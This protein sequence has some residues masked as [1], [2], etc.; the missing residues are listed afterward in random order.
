MPDK[1]SDN[2]LLVSLLTSQFGARGRY[3]RVQ[4][5]RFPDEP[6]RWREEWESG[7]IPA[8]RERGPLVAWLISALFLGA[9]AVVAILAWDELT[10]GRE[11]LLWL[12]LIFPLVGVLMLV[13]ALIATARALRYGR[14]VLRL[15]ATPCRLG[16]HVQGT[17]D[18]QGTRLPASEDAEIE[19]QERHLF[20]QKTQDSTRIEWRVVWSQRFP[21]VLRGGETCLP[22]SLPIPSDGQGIDPAQLA[23]TDWRVRLHAVTAGP[24]VNVA[25]LVPVFAG[26]DGD[27][28]Q[29]RATIE[30]A[31]AQAT[32]AGG[33]KRLVHDLRRS[34]VSLR[35]HPG[36]LELWVLPIGWRRPGFAVTGAVFTAL[37][38]IVWALTVHS[39]HSL[40]WWLLVLPFLLLAALVDTLTFTKFLRVRAGQR[41]LR[42]VRHILGVPSVWQVPYEAISSIRPH[43]SMSSSGA[44]GTVNYYDLE[45]CWQ[46]GAKSRT[47]HLGLGITDKALATALANAFR[48][49]HP[50]EF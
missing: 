48:A 9:G 4:K 14:P 41:G 20:V 38:A 27:K 31:A 6:W 50:T 34:G 35:R 10:S 44:E 30:A 11:P 29:T 24:D 16:G 19:L 47:V 13:N 23:S 33:E 5:A 22:V 39:H 7:V 25:F 3:M 26:T 49:A 45:I 1:P 8:S 32:A 40:W 18:F 46:T 36:G 37:P 21:L 17:I 2:G 43:S 42:I 15:D 28:G 12:F